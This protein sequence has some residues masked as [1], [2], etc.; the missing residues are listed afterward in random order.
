MFPDTKTARV[1]TYIPRMSKKNVGIPYSFITLSVYVCGAVQPPSIQLHSHV[2]HL[3]LGVVPCTADRSNTTNP[4]RDRSA[5]AGMTI[6]RSNSPVSAVK[7]PR[8]CCLPNSQSSPSFHPSFYT[9]IVNYVRD[10]AS[11]KL[12]NLHVGQQICNKNINSFCL[13]LIHWT[14]ITIFS[15]S[16]AISPASAG[17][18]GIYT[19]STSTQNLGTK[20][21]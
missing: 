19:Q 17:T 7:L 5:G 6:P 11:V 21:Y 10:H 3:P 4:Q 16:R 13:S 2:S 20:K 1:Y 14:P 15:I 18:C 12:L 9:T 8:E